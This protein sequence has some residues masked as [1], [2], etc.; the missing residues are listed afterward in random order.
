MSQNEDGTWD[1]KAVAAMRFQGNQLYFFLLWSNSDEGWV[2][3]DD[4][5]SY[6]SP[7]A[8]LNSIIT[9]KNWDPQNPKEGQTV[10]HSAFSNNAFP[11]G[12][13]PEHL[14]KVYKDNKRYQSMAR[15]S[16][17]QNPDGSWDVKEIIAM[18]IKAEQ[19]YFYMHWAN[20]DKT[21]IHVDDFKSYLPPLAFWYGMVEPLEWSSY[22]APLAFWNEMIEL[23]IY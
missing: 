23:S 22:L 16:I 5:T 20:D 4:L 19:V 6:L 11:L 15:S 12:P 3:I 1:V 8:F 17:G 18:K 9:P 10:W 14:L 13:I 2:H 7:L 21:W